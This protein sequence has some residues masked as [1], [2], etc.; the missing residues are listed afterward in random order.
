MDAALMDVPPK[1]H[2]AGV[3]AL[4]SLVNEVEDLCR[5]Y[6]GRDAESE[7]WIDTCKRFERLDR[8]VKTVRKAEPK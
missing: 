6:V 8:L 2:A 7:Q 4:K 1:V 5:V 3:K